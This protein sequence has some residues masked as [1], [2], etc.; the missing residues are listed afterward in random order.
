MAKWDLYGK[1]RKLAF[2][3]SLTPE[4]LSDAS[5]LGM[6]ESA[7]KIYPLFLAEKEPLSLKHLGRYMQIQGML[8]PLW[9][10]ATGIL[11]SLISNQKDALERLRSP[12][13]T[14]TLE[15]FLR[16]SEIQES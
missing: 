7:E 14:K 10:S 9:F 13:F 12:N 2:E 3:E 6:D 5:F 16:N 8:F 11:M 4:N 15:S 1:D